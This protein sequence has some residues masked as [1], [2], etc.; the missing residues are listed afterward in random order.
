M[1]ILDVKVKAEFCK[2]CKERK[3]KDVVMEGRTLGQQVW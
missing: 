3:N 2:T 1:T